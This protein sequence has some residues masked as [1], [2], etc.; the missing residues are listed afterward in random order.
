VFSLKAGKNDGVVA[1]GKCYDTDGVI[2]GEA[3]FPANDVN[4]KEDKMKPQIFSGANTPAWQ[5]T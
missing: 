2:I 3:R 1:R 4:K 5:A